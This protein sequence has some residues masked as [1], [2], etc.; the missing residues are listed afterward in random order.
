MTAQT[1]HHTRRYAGPKRTHRNQDLGPLLTH[2]MN[3]CIACYR[4][5]RFYRDH[6]GGRDLDAFGAH[7]RVYFGRAEDGVLESPF[8][9]NL[10]EICPTGVFNDRY[11]SQHYARR[12]DMNATPAI[13]QHCAVGCNITLYERNGTLR[14]VQNRYHGAIN[15]FFLCDRGR[16]GPMFADG[17][18][19]ISV[20][21]HRGAAVDAEAALG[22]ARAATDKG[23][24]G[25]GSPRASLE[26]NFALRRLV[27]PERFFAG[28]SDREAALVQRMAAIL[29]D[30][31]AR[32]AT[33]KDVEASDA[34]LVLGEDLTGTAP[35][36]ALALRQAARGAERALAQEKGVADWLDAAVR[37]AG[38][39]RRSPITLVTPMP[40]ALDD[41]AVQAL[42]RRPDQV[43]GF[44]FAVAEVLK[45]AASPDPEV[46]AAA[47]A[48][49]EAKA[50]LVVA[51]AG[52]GLAGP[53]EAA[54]AVAAALGP[55]ARI[56]LFPPEANSLG[57]ALLGGAGLDS[58]V[59]VLDRDP[60]AVI[61]LE[62]DLSRRV[63]PEALDRLHAAATSVIVLDCLEGGTAARADLVL[64]V[65]SFAEAAGTVVNHEGRAQRGFAARPPA[66]PA[67][68]RLLSRLG[69]GMFGGGDETLDDVLAA[70]AGDFP[71][72][73]AA[74]SAAP[75]A[76]TPVPVARAPAPYSGRTASDRAGRVAG[77]TPPHDPD[78][79][80]NWS[81][82]GLRGDRVPPALS[83]G[84]AV[85]GLHSV[86][87]A[88][89]AQQTIGGPLEGGDPGTALLRAG[90]GSGVAAVL[91]D[92]ATRDAP[93]FLCLPLHDPFSA[94]ETDGAS[95]I[96]AKRAPAPRIVLHPQDAAG[97]G[98]AAG[99]AVVLDGVPALAPVTLDA[100]MPRG[101]VGLSV[102]IVASRVGNRRIRIGAAP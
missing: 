18:A 98:L 7:D 66:A 82:E 75:K 102:G 89:H 46:A 6:A 15:G 3:R 51:G 28:V 14:Q 1:G 79:A 81:M 24:I 55:R 43:A 58:A 95:P 60:C 62:N 96:L 73:A 39:G 30:G 2:E 40:D 59:A 100:G 50:P 8:A 92:P 35:R 91:A 42:R 64:P 12:W 65:A 88:Y 71:D 29:R 11:W 16:F 20:P 21:R 56:A 76:G 57:L 53:V 80:M 83:T 48:L 44:G 67:S 70:L 4:C 61:V 27:G 25:I 36:A 77:G 84:P 41:I 49:A 87:A 5:V 101:H 38:E 54:A 32:I 94:T 86:S 33:L 97:L 17:P 74:A 68:W 93:G 85:P 69:G 37:V 47:R 9:G 72:L 99:A 52:L 19:R 26:A 31:P 45:G 13:C 22:L 90:G 78:S 23:A 63:A 10:A 34:V